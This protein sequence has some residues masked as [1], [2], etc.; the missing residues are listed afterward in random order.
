MKLDL[1]N[2]WNAPIHRFA[3][4]NTVTIIP[5]C[6]DLNKLPESF[7]TFSTS[8]LALGTPANVRATKV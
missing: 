1:A 3:C 4:K 7:E 6:L 8:R 2:A 5:V